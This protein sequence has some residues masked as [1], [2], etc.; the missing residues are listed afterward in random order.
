MVESPKPVAAV[1]KSKESYSDKCGTTYLSATSIVKDKYRSEELRE[2]LYKCYD[3]VTASRLK[4]A[5][6]EEARELATKTEEAKREVAQLQI[7]LEKA[8]ELRAK[9]EAEAAARDAL[10]KWSF[11]ECHSN[12]GFK[13]FESH[14]KVKWDN[15]TTY[16]Y[17]TTSAVPPVEAVK[18]TNFSSGANN[19]HTFKVRVVDNQLR[20]TT[21]F[22]F[23]KDQTGK[24]GD[25]KYGID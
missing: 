15:T 19:V 18:V 13:V 23:V 24:K 21:M 8:E 6:F 7:N 17:S 12:S 1:V 14:K 11:D 25:S 16:K 20:R 9:R 3:K 22:G 4:A 5:E 10:S 2:K